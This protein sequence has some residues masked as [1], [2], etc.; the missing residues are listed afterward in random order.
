MAEESE[1]LAYIGE[2]EKILLTQEK[3]KE[4]YISKKNSLLVKADLAAASIDQLKSEKMETQKSIDTINLSVEDHEKKLKELE[5]KRTYILTGGGKNADLEVIKE[6]IED[7]SADRSALEDEIYALW[8]KIEGVES[9]IEQAKNELDTIK[10]EVDTKA[11]EIDDKIELINNEIEKINLR[12]HEKL[13]SLSKENTE[14]YNFCKRLRDKDIMPS[15]VPLRGS[16]CS[17]CNCNLP[18]DV[19]NK[20]IEG[21]LVNCPLCNRFLYFIEEPETA[22]E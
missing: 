10:T 6:Q 21:Q 19:V 5:Q 22:E 11:V 1:I 17:G 9:R 13:E 15:A 2:N 3:E 16:V 20:V 4:S 7:E 12:I 8:E 14:A 18:P